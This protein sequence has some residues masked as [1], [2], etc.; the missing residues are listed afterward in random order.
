VQTKFDI[1]ILVPPDLSMMSLGLDGQASRLA[2]LNMLNDVIMF[3]G[4]LTVAFVFFFYSAVL[5]LI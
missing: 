2:L 5:C 1:N 3:S 4:A